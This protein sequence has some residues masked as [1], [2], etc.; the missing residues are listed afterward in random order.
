MSEPTRYKTA[1]AE[2]PLKPWAIK[3]LASYPDP[4]E[5][6]YTRTGIDA[7]TQTTLYFDADGQPVEMAGHGTNQSTSSPTA[8]GADGGGAQP[9]APAD[10]DALEDHVPD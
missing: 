1:P 3:R 7:T 6:P 2:S 9:P 10:S 5:L 4:V 8:T